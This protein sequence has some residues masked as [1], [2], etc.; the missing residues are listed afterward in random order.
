[1]RFGGP[2]V[3]LVNISTA[4]RRDL[5]DHLGTIVDDAG[6][7]LPANLQRE[8]CIRAAGEALEECVS[9]V[10]LTMAGESEVAGLAIHPMAM[11]RTRQRAP[12]RT[13]FFMG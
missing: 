11:P 9:G 13:V 10:S 12:V 6:F 8:L 7:D 2:V 4:S 3:P 1:M 5:D